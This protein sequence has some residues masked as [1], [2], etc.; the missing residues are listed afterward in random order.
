MQPEKADHLSVA[1]FEFEIYKF[2]MYH[3]VYDEKLNLL[4]WA[5]APRI[6]KMFANL[7]ISLVAKLFSLLC[8]S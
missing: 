7:L 3:S 4:T 1:C 8:N 2:I 5:I 6:I